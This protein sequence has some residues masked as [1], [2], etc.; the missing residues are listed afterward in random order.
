M[1]AKWVG[2]DSYRKEISSPSKRHPSLN[3]NYMIHKDIF[4]ISI[5]NLSSNQG[6]LKT[7]CPGRQDYELAHKYWETSWQQLTILRNCGPFLLSTL[8]PETCNERRCHTRLNPHKG[9][10]YVLLMFLKI[11]SKTNKCKHSRKGNQYV[12]YTR[13][14]RACFSTTCNR[15]DIKSIYYS[16]T[17]E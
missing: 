5:F 1:D 14:H 16:S 8:V 11:K 2:Q 12:Q 13:T 7:C 15:E 6:S 9:V 10:L 3:Q 17:N 4:Y